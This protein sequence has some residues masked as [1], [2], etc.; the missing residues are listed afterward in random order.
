MQGGANNNYIA[1]HG[2]VGPHKEFRSLPSTTTFQINSEQQRSG[3][4]AAKSE[5]SIT[6]LTPKGCNENRASSSFVTW[7][8]TLYSRHYLSS[9]PAISRIQECNEIL[10]TKQAGVTVWISYLTILK[11]NPRVQSQNTV[12]A[13]CLRMQAVCALVHIRVA[14]SR[15]R[16][17]R[18]VLNVNTACYCSVVIVMDY[19]PDRNGIR[20]FRPVHK[21]FSFPVQP[22]QQSMMVCAQEGTRLVKTATISSH[23]QL[24]SEQFKTQFMYCG[25]IVLAICKHSRV[26]DIWAECVEN[27]PTCSFQHPTNHVWSQQVLSYAKIHNFDGTNYIACELKDP[28]I[29]SN[30]LESTLPCFIH[31]VSLRILRSLYLGQKD[32]DENNNCLRPCVIVSRCL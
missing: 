31:V 15:A 14:P 19:I 5:P 22:A 18:S 27:L 32:C 9:S 17:A 7:V 23:S 24:E 11:Y 25:P 20:I 6:G 28:Q 10:L 8:R 1:I 4:Y 12:H 3:E 13:S 21:S 30:R 29:P 26:L 2:A 16:D